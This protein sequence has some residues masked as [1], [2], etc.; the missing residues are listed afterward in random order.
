MEQCD[1]QGGVPVR[2][3]PHNWTKLTLYERSE[4]IP[5]R[6]AGGH[7]KILEW[8]TTNKGCNKVCDFHIH[9]Y[10][11]LALIYALFTWFSSASAPHQSLCVEFM[12]FSMKSEPGMMPQTFQL[13]RYEVGKQDDIHDNNSRT[14]LDLTFKHRGLRRNTNAEGSLPV[15]VFSACFVVYK[16]YRRVSALFTYTGDSHL[17]SQLGGGWGYLELGNS[18]FRAEME[19]SNKTGEKD[20]KRRETHI[21][22]IKKS[23][24]LVF[25]P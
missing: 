17:G 18:N 5:S 22:Y 7:C 23:V 8:L 14:C 13:S 16:K 15:L 21:L 9:H 6:V 2:G 12:Y 25:K 24:Y 11:S 1:N 20:R 3:V 19:C 4:K 10:V